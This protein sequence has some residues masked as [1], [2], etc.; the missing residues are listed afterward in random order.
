MLPVYPPVRFRI[1]I[2]DSSLKSLKEEYAEALAIL[3][4]SKP[5]PCYLRKSLSAGSAVSSFL[6][7][8]EIP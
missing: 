2:R 7:G 5:V 4:K 1:D 8:R 6:Y 3:R